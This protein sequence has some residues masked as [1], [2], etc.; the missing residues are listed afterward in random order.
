MGDDTTLVEI[1]CYN[2]HETLVH[3]GDWY[4]SYKEY[5]HDERSRAPYCCPK[6]GESVRYKE[7]DSSEL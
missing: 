1:V 3:P 6:C 4:E 5:S 7:V 2:E